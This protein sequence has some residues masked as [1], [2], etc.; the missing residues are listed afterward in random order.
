MKIPVTLEFQLLF[1][2]IKEYGLL[3]SY[4]LF[5]Y[6]ITQ[7]NNYT[8]RK[9]FGNIRQKI[10]IFILKTNKCQLSK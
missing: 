2:F 1:G 3:D 5:G 9:R 4:N 6:K 8:F 10:A 7:E